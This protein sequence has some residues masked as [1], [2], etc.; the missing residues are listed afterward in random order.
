[1]KSHAHATIPAQR[2]SCDKEPNNPYKVYI[3]VKALFLADGSLYPYE[4]TWEDGVRFP[5]EAIHEIRPAAAQKAGGQGDRYTIVIQGKETYLFFE[6]NPQPA[7]AS[8][9]RWFVERK[10]PLRAT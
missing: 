8:L 2:W 3:T 4:I 6:R 1:M 5:I 9:G 7:L 10:K